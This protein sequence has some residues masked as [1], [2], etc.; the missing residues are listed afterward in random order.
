MMVTST[1]QRI[2]TITALAC[3]LLTPRFDVSAAE[4]PANDGDG[5]ISLCS[6]D[7]DGAP[8]DDTSNDND[9]PFAGPGGG[10]GGTIGSLPTNINP[11]T[12]CLSAS[13]LP[14]D[15]SFKTGETLTFSAPSGSGA[16]AYGWIV[17]GKMVYVDDLPASSP[18]VTFITKEVKAA[19]LAC[20]TLVLVFFGPKG[21]VVAAADIMKLHL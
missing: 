9:A 11:L 10:T 19:Q 2:L 12:T 6:S 18:V 16:C 7:G 15:K 21:G 8:N 1:L 5:D 13:Y 20:D 3:V 17:D 14:P 4:D